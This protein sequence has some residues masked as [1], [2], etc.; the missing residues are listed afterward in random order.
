MEEERVHGQQL[1]WG[2]TKCG[3]ESGRERKNIVRQDIPNQGQ[4]LINKI[5]HLHIR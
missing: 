5:P 4:I 2:R 1:Q 3:G